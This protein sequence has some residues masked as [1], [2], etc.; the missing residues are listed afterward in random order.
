MYYRIIQNNCLAA[1]KIHCARFVHPF[2]L[3]WIK[4]F[5]QKRRTPA[6]NFFT[7]WKNRWLPPAYFTQ[8]SSHP[9]T[10]AAWHL[11]HTGF[12]L[13][14]WSV[15]F[16]FSLSLFFRYFIKWCKQIFSIFIFLLFRD[17]VEHYRY[18]IHWLDHILAIYPWHHFIVACTDS[19]HFLPLNIRLVQK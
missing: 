7:G 8:F 9:F 14:L 6:W 13:R 18:F 16:L 12:L 1:P 4:L 15:H 19:H 10:S 3:W 17:I 2:V 5:L 11:T